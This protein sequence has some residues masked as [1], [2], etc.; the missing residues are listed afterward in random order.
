VTGAN[1]VLS[2]D[3]LT[4]GGIS[5]FSLSAD[6]TAA[7][8]PAIYRVTF[9]PIHTIPSNNLIVIKFPPTTSGI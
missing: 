6:T 4:P 5:S 2:Q 9:L 1:L 8:M 3:N 7:G